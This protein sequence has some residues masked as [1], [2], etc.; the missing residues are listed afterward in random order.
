MMDLGGQLKGREGPFLCE[1]LLLFLFVSVVLTLG[2]LT[3]WHVRA[4]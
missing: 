3:G 1:S 2:V 4:G